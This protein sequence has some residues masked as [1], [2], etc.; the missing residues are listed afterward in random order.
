MDNLVVNERAL[1]MAYVSFCGWFFLGRKGALRKAINRYIHAVE[2]YP[3]KHTETD[4][5]NGREK[6]EIEDRVFKEMDEKYPTQNP[7]DFAN[8]RTKRKCE[9]RQIELKRAK[10][11]D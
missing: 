4:C 11:K 2:L 10:A 3:N 1:K 6:Q 5:P 8:N 9:M 7:D